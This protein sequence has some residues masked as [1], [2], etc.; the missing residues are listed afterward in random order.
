MVAVEGPS[1]EGKV[2]SITVP[3]ACFIGGVARVQMEFKS[4]LGHVM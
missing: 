4:R 3:L 2:L 1:T